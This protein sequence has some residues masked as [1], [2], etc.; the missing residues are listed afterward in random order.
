MISLTPVLN[1]EATIPLYR[2]LFHYIRDAIVN[3]DIFPGDKLPSLRALSES[4]N[5]SV[6]TVELAYDQLLLE[7]Y[8]NSRP[9]SGYYVS[10]I[11]Y[12]DAKVPLPDSSVN[13]SSDT[14]PARLC[15]IKD[16][17]SRTYVDPACFDFTKWK[18]CFNKVINDHSSLLLCEGDIQGEPP[19]RDEI[20]RYIYQSRGV[21]CSLEQVIIAAG[22]QQLINILCIILE[23][24]G[25]DHVSFEN[26]GYVPVRSIF[27][28]RGFKMTLV[29]IDR[30]GVRIE[31]L[32]ANIPSAVYVSPS[33]Q[34]PT[35]SVMPA[36]R[37]YAL[38]DWAERNGSIIIEDDYNSELR[39]DSRP[40][41][42][43][44][45]LDNREQVVY[46]GSFSSTLFP[47]IKISYMVLPEPLHQLFS[48]S[49][50]DYVQTCSKAEQLT[51]ALYMSSGYYQTNLKKQRKLN[52]QKIQLATLALN[53]HRGE[54]IQILNNSSGLHMLIKFQNNGKTPEE[55]CSRAA[56][57][58]LTLA[59][60]K[61][62]ENENDF[63]V[64]MFYYTRISI[65]NIKQAVKD[66]V[67]ILCEH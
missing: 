47:S 9:R 3:R 33:N 54:S 18:N 50:K 40:V 7:G 13:L 49:L 26:P 10:N 57:A 17:G 46:L 11:S 61:G 24:M 51:L 59:P 1:E 28:D 34:F 36:G 63:S 6:T 62:Y 25:I 20:S 64:V 52:A 32:P 16:K 27:K 43:L 44:Q 14:G 58:G 39:Y 60:V 35:G 15:A 56:S 12:G 21:R 19:L 37:R 22:T 45:G 38:L 29:P 55:I 8:I 5:I 67:L 53:A 4:L 66:L 48:E 65:D 30:D 23:R 2:Q 41:P 31:K 42:S